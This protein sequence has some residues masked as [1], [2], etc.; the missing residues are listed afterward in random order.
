MRNPAEGWS[1]GLV[2]RL[3]VADG[4]EIG[5]SRIESPRRDC[6]RRGSHTTGHAEPHPAVGPT[7]ILITRGLMA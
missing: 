2:S 6:A 7:V 1:E 5:I 3:G 4:V